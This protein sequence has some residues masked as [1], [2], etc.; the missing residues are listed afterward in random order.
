MASR[1]TKR[2]ARARL[3]KEKQKKTQKVNEE[4]KRIRGV[5]DQAIRVITAE[6]KYQ[7][8]KLRLSLRTNKQKNIICFGCGKAGHLARQCRYLKRNSRGTVGNVK[9]FR[10]GQ[11]GHVRRECPQL[12]I[13][14]HSGVEGSH[15]DDGVIGQLPEL[16]GG[17]CQD[18]GL[19]SE[20][21][22][23]GK[24]CVVS[25]DHVGI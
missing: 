3:W 10:C 16:Q 17:K 24:T 20:Q 11:L 4:I 12:R 22:E 5:S 9:C 2:T 19:P 1:N 7:I 13:Q 6:S 15:Q 21:I 8:K 23:V 18:I 14:N 25:P